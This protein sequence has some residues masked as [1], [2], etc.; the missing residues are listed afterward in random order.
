MPVGSTADLAWT[1]IVQISQST[2]LHRRRQE[3]QSWVG[4]VGEFV[5]SFCTSLRSW[6]L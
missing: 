4:D 3:M 6:T 2:S 5:V 1:K